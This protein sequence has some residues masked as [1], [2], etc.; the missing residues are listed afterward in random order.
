[1]KV[2]FVLGTTAGGTGRHVQMLAA[3]CAA[4]G[5]QAEVFAPGET[6]RAFPFGSGVVVRTVEFTDR[7][8]PRDGWA[9][10]R[11]RRLIARSSADAVHAHGLRAGALAALALAFIRPGR[12]PPLVVTVHN[13]PLSAG[14]T[15]AI[16]RALEQVVARGAATVLCVS[17]D[18][19]ERMRQAGACDV[20][21]ALVPSP[22]AGPG[23]A[24]GTEAGEA[25]AAVRKEL[26]GGTGRPIVLA[27]GRLAEQKD[28]ASLIDAARQW[29]GLGPVP[30]LAIAGSGPLAESLAERAAPL[31]P[32]VRFLGPRP[33][34]PVLLAAAGVFVL[35]SRWEGQPLILQEA[36]AA[37]C[38]IVAS[39]AGGIPDLTGE[40]AALLVP[41][42]DVDALAA[43]IRRV[44]TDP[45]LAQRLAAGARER[46]QALPSQDAAIDAALA[47]YRRLAAA[48]GVRGHIGR[49]SDGPP[50]M[51]PQQ[52]ART[53]PVV[54]YS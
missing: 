36:L 11:L 24:P 7:P 53:G 13:A 25:A 8:R 1:V 42:G 48:A 44:L 5:L 29:A 51:R 4:R 16:Y 2:A 6:Q 31:G 46:A 34:V 47:T 49:L 20:G 9:V 39:R 38:P 22:A 33:D 10:L 17:A 19:E 14:V 45:V 21:R 32:A 26:T 50:R 30:L 43:A 52:R 23:A 35:P 12:R 18:L 54:T 37:G 28:L 41:P 27:A 40:D 15:G 3:G